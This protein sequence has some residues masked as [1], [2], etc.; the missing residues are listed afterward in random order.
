MNTQDMKL[1]ALQKALDGE[2]RPEV[3]LENFNGTWKLQCYCH[4]KTNFSFNLWG[5]DLQRWFSFGDV[6]EREADIFL[7]GV[8]HVT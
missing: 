7:K 1:A 6:S 8:G 2:E 5:K 3:F 4:E